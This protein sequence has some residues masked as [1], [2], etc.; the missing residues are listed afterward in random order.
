MPTTAADVD[1]LCITT[2]RTLSMDAVQKANSGH[3]GAPMGMAP[4]AYL[5]WDR[6]LRHNPA[7]PEWPNRDRFV[8]SIGHA[9]MLLYSLLHLWRYGVTLDDLKSFRQ[10]NSPCAGHPERGLAPGVEMTTGPLGQGVATSVGMAIAERW[11]AATFNRPEHRVVDYRVF[12]LCGDGD[13]MEGVTSEAASLAGHLGLGNLVWIYDNNHVTIEGLTGITFTEDVATRFVAYNWAVERVGDANDLQALSRA[14]EAATKEPNRPSLIIVD[15]HIAYG[16]PNKQDTPGAHGE[17]L[18]EEEIRATKQRYGWDPDWHFHVPDEVRAAMAEKRARGERLE[19]EWLT[20]FEA[21]SEAYPDLARQWSLIQEGRLPPGWDADIP[22]FATDDKG[23]AGRQA[24]SKVLNAIAHKVPWLI[25]GSAD[26]AP[27]T[28]T[29]IADTADFGRE[30]EG[31]RN[32][33]FGVREH[34]MGAVLNGLALSKLRPV[35]ST[36]LTFSDYSRP[37]IRL[38]A[39]MRLPVIYVFTH[40]SICVGE[41]G[42]THQPIEQLASLRATP[43]L[44]VF[45]PADANEIVV[46]WR[47][48]MEI[49]DRPVALVLTR[50]TVLTIDRNR[51][52]SAD[53][54]GRGGYVLAD[55]HGTPEVILIGTGSEVQLCLGAAERLAKEGLRTRVVSL[56][57]WRL[58]EAQ[59]AEY[60][61]DVL[62]PAVRARVAVEAASTFGWSRYVGIEGSIIGIGQSDFGASAPIGAL[63]K[64]FGFTVERIVE[65]ARDQV[66]KHTRPR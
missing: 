56:P 27:S 8:L 48:I 3:P 5:L 44:L 43:R 66:R 61:E 22:T 9:S 7:N 16:S 14:F 4:C 50:Q 58:F 47:C 35:G 64:Q 51:Y 55:S 11:L 31:G 32:L 45:R 17:P 33:H 20:R 2:I 25:G 49:G 36:F 54:L 57:C 15:S 52:A 46:A 1:Q 30:S 42:P 34:A 39:L 6:I 59:S 12:A 19:A 29:H 13:M 26:L 38:S 21:Y 53:G 60:Q 40:D 10:L 37:A 62:P 41:D 63:L 23:L 18:G 28:K 65:A 24:S